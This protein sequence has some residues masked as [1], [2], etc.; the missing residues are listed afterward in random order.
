VRALRG[1]LG[2]LAV[3]D[4][5]GRTLRVTHEHPWTRE[6][7][8]LDEDARLLLV[9]LGELADEDPPRVAL[10]VAAHVDEYGVVTATLHAGTAELWV[11]VGDGWE[12]AIWTA[13][14]RTY[15]WRWEDG[16]SP[17]VVRALFD[18]RAFERRAMVGRRVLSAAIVCRDEAG[19]E[20]V[21]ALDGVGGPLAVVAAAVRRAG[22]SRTRVTRMPGP[23][24][25]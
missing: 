5:S 9:F 25:P 24:V 12:R 17:A 2:G 21:V 14:G 4:V 1:H 3:A 22:M 13:S 6:E 10:P 7:A 15:E 8:D 16:A 20:V 18:G 11:Q 19:R 23:D